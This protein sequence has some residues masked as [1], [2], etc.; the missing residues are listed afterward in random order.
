MASIE[1]LT[2]VHCEILGT[3][4][5]GDLVLIQAYAK[6]AS[7]YGSDDD[8][9][10]GSEDGEDVDNSNEDTEAGDEAG[11]EMNDGQEIEDATNDAI[12]D[13]S[14]EAD[15]SENEEAIE[16]DEVDSVPPPPP[17]VYIIDGLMKNADDNITE[18]T[19][20][21]LTYCSKPAD[22]T[23]STFQIYGRKVKVNNASANSATVTVSDSS[24]AGGS[25][26]QSTSSNST[27]QETGVSNEEQTISIKDVIDVEK[28]DHYVLLK[29]SGHD[30]RNTLFNGRCP[31]YC[32]EGYISTQEAM[33]MLVTESIRLVSPYKPVCPVCIGKRLMRQLQVLR[34]TYQDQY[35]V[36]IGTVVD[37]YYEL[38]PRRKALGYS[39]IQL[40]ER[41]W[42]M[43]YDDML[44]E[45]ED[46]DGQPNGEHWEQWAEANDP[47]SNPTYHPASDAS[48]AA[49]PQK[50]FGDVENPEQ[51]KC[52]VCIQAF[53]DDAVVAELPCGHYF[54]VECAQN[55]L[56]KSNS[57]PAC[58]KKLPAVEG[59]PAEPVDKVEVGYLGDAESGGEGSIKVKKSM[60]INSN[61]VNM[62]GEDVVMSDAEGDMAVAA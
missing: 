25:N 10:S 55:W 46:G 16:D 43:Q 52:L 7:K 54:D 49:L 3:A 53:V 12:D 47:N 14:D 17:A 44:S 40:D 6:P 28:F 23:S 9:D 37:F 15:Y 35:L 21:K 11:S 5:I 33:H 13:D 57:C 4:Q 62:D 60:N 34:E 38:N 59:E 45:S 42:G 61:E 36:D 19:L 8:P 2:E 1:G 41:E 29:P 30:I 31:A 18:I 22:A 58:R 56:K 27:E 20:R 26:K 51:A 39:F 50:T 24:S 48:I 32:D